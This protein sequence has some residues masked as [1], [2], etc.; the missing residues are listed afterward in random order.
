MNGEAMIYFDNSATTHTKPKQVL[1]AVNSALTK[2]SANPGRG[3]HT[4]GISCAMQVNLVREKLRKMFNAN[5]IEHVIFTSGCTEALNLAILGSEQKGHVVC[6]VNDH[7]SVLRPLHFLKEKGS[8]TL[9]IAT[10]QDNE[11]LTWQDIE[12]HIQRDTYLVCVNHISNVDGMITDIEQIGKQCKQRNILFLVDAAQSAGHVQI[13]MQ[14]CC[15]DF[16]AIAPHKGLYAPQGIGA[17]LISDSKHLKPIRFGGTGTESFSPSQPSTPP[18]CFESGTLAV[19]AILGMGAGIDFVQENFNDIKEKLE[20]LTT[21]LN[22]ELRK[23]PGITVFTHPNNAFGVISF[24]VQGMESEEVGNI[25]NQKHNICVRS[26]LHCAPLKHQHMN[27]L[28]TG[29]VRVSLSY[30]NHFGQVITLIKAIKK[31]VKQNI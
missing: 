1:A 11:K 5:K 22:F 10:P 25:L 2:F 16:L 9:S 21:Y 17:L 19:P 18:E 3:A 24:V 15:I 30:F 4:V 12:K 8:I 7:N 27:T 31:I 6:T 14:K 29:T 26:G 28:S 13:D 23:I 20:D